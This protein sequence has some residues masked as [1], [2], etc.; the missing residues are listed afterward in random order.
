MEAKERKEG[1]QHILFTCYALWQI[2]KSRNQC[3]FKQE[4]LSYQH[5]VQKAWEEWIEFG[6]IHSQQEDQSMNATLATGNMGRGQPQEGTILIKLAAATNPHNGK[7][8]YG[9]NARSCNGTLLAAWALMDSKNSD[10]Q[11][12]KLA[13]EIIQDIEWK[14]QFPSWILPDPCFCNG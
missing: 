7:T 4:K 9:I 12:A 3:V 5:A 14:D 13:L 1:R 10:T 8:G 11:F 6:S 2:W